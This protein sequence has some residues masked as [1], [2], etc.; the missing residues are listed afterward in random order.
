MRRV[1]PHGH[2]SHQL[3]QLHGLA[4]ATDRATVA[5]PHRRGPD[6]ELVG[7]LLVAPALEEVLGDDRQSP[8]RPILG[9]ID[10]HLFEIVRLALV[11]IVVVDRDF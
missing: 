8:C 4:D 3:E 11:A 6:P 9:R 1:G 2:A 5:L 7:D 10:R